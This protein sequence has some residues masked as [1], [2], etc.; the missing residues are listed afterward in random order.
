MTRKKKIR[1]AIVAA[2][3]LAISAGAVFALAE[4]KRPG[5]SKELP[6][7]RVR[8]GTVELNVYTMGEL[9]PPRSMIITAPSVPGT[10]T[11]VHLAKTGT[12]VSAGD[13]VLEFDPSD[14]EYQLEMA[15]SRLNEARQQITRAQA[16]AAVQAAQD[17][18]SLLRAKFDVRRAEL[19]VQKNELVGDI[20]K[21][22]N[23]LALEEAKRRQEQMQKDVESRAVAAE[24]GIAVLRQQE[25]EAEISMMRARQ[26]IQNMVVKSPIDGVVTVRDNA[27]ILGYVRIFGMIFP[28]YREGDSVWPGRTV[29]E[30][31]AT[32]QMEVMGKIDEGDRSNISS[33]Q[34]AEIRV[35]GRPGVVYTARVKAISGTLSRRTMWGADSMRRFDTT[36][37][38]EH[39]DKA[40]RP[41]VT[42]DVTIRGNQLKDVLF[43]PRQCLFDKAGKQVV[44][45]RANGGFEPREVKINNRTESQIVVEGLQENA[46]VALVNPE[47][48]GKA[49]SKAATQAGPPAIGGGGR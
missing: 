1:V 47:E 8:R 3:V 21:K 25:A 38:L 48:Q 41:G 22:K 45:V 5:G 20:D 10:L 34:I 27:D 12:H 24:A 11:I 37:T 9:R 46:E 26:N 31:L 42:A 6:T 4:F 40:V 35:N 28:E 2:C 18:V 14:Q 16:D 36:L 29:A 32:D 15:Q 49:A 23:L 30:V 39:I 13:V 19:E 17:K 7:T 44:Y 43:L 33:G